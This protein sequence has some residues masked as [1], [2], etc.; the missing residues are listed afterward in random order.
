MPDSNTSHSTG[1]SDPAKRVMRISRFMICVTRA[2]VTWPTRANSARSFTPPRFSRSSKWIASAIGELVLVL[3][4]EAE[5]LPDR[6][7]RAELLRA[8]RE[9]GVRVT[10]LVPG[11]HADHLLTRRSSRRLYGELLQGRVEIHEY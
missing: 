4:Q 8:I 2:R 9:R 6:S 1:S 5:L 7:V 11:E 3:G 10:V